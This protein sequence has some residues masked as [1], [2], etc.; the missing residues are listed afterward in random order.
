MLDVVPPV[1]WLVSGTI[2]GISAGVLLTGGFWYVAAA[3]VVGLVFS[4]VM[5]V[6][7]TNRAG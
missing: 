3:P 6:I 7:T 4:I 2:C 1:V 5:F